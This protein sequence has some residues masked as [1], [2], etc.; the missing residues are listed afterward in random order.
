MI[1]PVCWLEAESLQFH[2]YYV[3]MQR[4]QFFSREKC[5]KGSHTYASAH[6]NILPFSKNYFE[7]F[8]ELIFTVKTPTDI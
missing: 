2:K 7:N 6:K 4:E 3:G 1:F 5:T 8:A